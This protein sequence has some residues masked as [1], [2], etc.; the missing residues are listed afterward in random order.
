MPRPSPPRSRSGKKA[1]WK[2]NK[3]GYIGTIG[4]PK[5]WMEPVIPLAAKQETRLKIPAPADGKAVTLFLAASDAGDG[6]EHDFV[7]WERPR[8]VQ[9]GQP[10]VLIRDLDGVLDPALFGG[11]PNGESVDPASLCVRAPSMIEIRLP[12]GLAA[13]CEFVTTGVL[14]KASGAEGSAQL[15]V[16]TTKPES[17][18]GLPSKMSPGRP[19]LVN[20]GSATRRRIKSAF[21]AFRQLFPAALCYTQVVPV[22]EGVTLSL[23]HRDDEHLARLML[24]D[25]QKARLD[26]LW[27]EL[28]Y[29]SRDALAIVDALEQLSEY[30]TSVGEFKFLD[31]LREPTKQ[32]AAAFRERLI[33]TETAAP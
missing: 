13:G 9:K 14:E 15:Q 25:A 31:P 4:G 6:N 21:D 30:A 17:A 33:D 24:D 1:L 23:L 29:V 10:D 32:R 22:D 18:S 11:H 2:L 19:V 16:L 27:D 5:A 26:R 7:V 8:L 28:H 3:V 20:D 12:T